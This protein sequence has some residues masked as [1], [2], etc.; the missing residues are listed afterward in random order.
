M[1]VSIYKLAGTFY[2]IPKATLSAIIVSAVWAIIVPPRVFY[3]YWKTS[4]ADFVASMLS[5]WVTLFV[6]VE[7]GIAAA[8]V[9]SIVYI[10]FRMAFTGVT[11]VGVLN[12][13]SV[14]A[15]LPAQLTV[16]EGEETISLRF[17][18]GES[19]LFANAYRIK[20][21]IIS[22]VK[23]ETKGAPKAD[24]PE[25]DRLWNQPR[26]RPGW[27][28]DREDVDQRPLLGQVTLDMTAVNH[29]DATGIEALLDLKREL[30]DYAGHSAMVFVG[31][32]NAVER[33]FRRASWTL[34]KM[35]G[36]GNG[37][38]ASGQIHP[39]SSGLLGGNSKDELSKIEMTTIE[40]VG[41]PSSG[42]DEEEIRST[43]S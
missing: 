1:L 34:E 38:L 23:S 37:E 42:E 40:H 7:M 25:A 8:V 14:H 39:S 27:A 15:D 2:W 18:I 35:M 6:S 12:T 9:Y 43:R 30:R 33:R 41:S 21:E 16:L 17:R 10:L 3:Q 29:V 20:D 32:N 28:E 4:F 13:N 22:H 36:M 19:I 31:L 26:K 5:F 24:V 11:Y